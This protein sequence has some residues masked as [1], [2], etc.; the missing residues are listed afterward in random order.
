MY[1][2]ILVYNAA[3]V[4]VAN[5]YVQGDTDMNSKIWLDQVTGA[6]IHDNATTDLEVLPGVTQASVHNNTIIAQAI[7]GDVTQLDHW[8]GRDTAPVLPV[9]VTTP[10]STPMIWSFFTGMLPDA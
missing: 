8:L 2:G 1:N 7:I 3:N 10:V 9:E 4:T 5:N 6:S